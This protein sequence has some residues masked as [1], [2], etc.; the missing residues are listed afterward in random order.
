VG[1]II[2]AAPPATAPLPTSEPG[3]LPRR[4]R[5]I[6][7][8]AANEPGMVTRRSLPLPPPWPQSAAAI[9]PVRKH[10]S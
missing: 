8:A 1:T 2:M 9:R 7:A 3:T 5:N 4:G 6:S 10:P